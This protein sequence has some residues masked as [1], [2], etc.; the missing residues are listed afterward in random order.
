MQTAVLG[1]RLVVLKN[2]SMGGDWVMADEALSLRK[3]NWL[4][5]ILLAIV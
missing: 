3:L 5:I 4:A 2:P 1:I